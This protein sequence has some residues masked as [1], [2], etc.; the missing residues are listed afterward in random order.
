MH[1]HTH[2]HTNTHTHT[3]THTDAKPRDN[4]TINLCL[5]ISVEK[6]QLLLNSP[7]K[8]SVKPDLRLLLNIHILHLFYASSIYCVYIKNNET[9]DLS[10]KCQRSTKHWRPSAKS[11]PYFKDLGLSIS[12]VITIT[13]INLHMFNV[14]WNIQTQLNR[15]FHRGYDT[16]CSVPCFCLRSS[17]WEL[18]ADLKHE[19]EAVR[20][21]LC[22]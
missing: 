14:S 20:S 8:I 2:T 19:T 18:V 12:S 1:Q 3:H 16:F 13:R 9:T 5:W 15:Q 21:H 17:Y 22:F 6:K 10:R 4:N 7:A 11:R